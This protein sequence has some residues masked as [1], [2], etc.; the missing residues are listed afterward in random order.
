MNVPKISA[1]FHRITIMT[2][3]GV[4]AATLHNASPAL[5]QESP[6]SSSESRIDAVQLSV[7][8]EEAETIV[9]PQ[10]VSVESAVQIVDEFNDGGELELV[11]L[12]FS[13]DAFWAGYV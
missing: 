11:A 2:L 5:A 9:L 1:G 6:A 13:S 12:D 10:P 7:S 4:M 8:M 3:A